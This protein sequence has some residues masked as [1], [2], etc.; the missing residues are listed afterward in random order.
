VE[1]SWTKKSRQVSF[2]GELQLPGNR[3]RKS[4]ILC[5]DRKRTSHAD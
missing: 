2:Y 4:Q 5:V 1:T 3:D